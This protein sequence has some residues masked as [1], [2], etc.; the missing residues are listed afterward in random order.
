[1]NVGRLSNAIG[2]GAIGHVVYSRLPHWT[3]AQNG[4]H[5][6]AQ[7]KPIEDGLPSNIKASFTCQA[8]QSFG[9]EVVDVIWKAKARP[10][11]ATYPAIPAR[12]IGDLDQSL[13][14]AGQHAMHGF[15]ASKRTALV[16]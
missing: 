2:V 12:E 11:L 14:I 10:L 4:I 15:Q 9:R 5:I 1:M 13:T 8:F 16:F 6:V 7:G 3:L